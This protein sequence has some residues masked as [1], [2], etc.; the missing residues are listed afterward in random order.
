M[1]VAEL[2]A[3]LQAINVSTPLIASLIAK[4][5]GGQAAGKTD[6]EIIAEALA[7]ANET[8]SITEHDMSQ[9]P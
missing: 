2:L 4:I 3:L 8:R 1:G 7:M 9:E 5:K 6:D